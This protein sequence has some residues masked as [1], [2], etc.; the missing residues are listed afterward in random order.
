MFWWILQLPVWSNLCSEK[1]RLNG[2][3]T[4]PYE[5]NTQHSPGSGRITI[6]QAV[7]S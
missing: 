2:Q 6:W 5:Q 4:V 1:T 7:H 3:G